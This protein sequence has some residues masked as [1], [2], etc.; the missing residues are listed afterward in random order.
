MAQTSQPAG[1][2]GAGADADTDADAEATSDQTRDE[3]EFYLEQMRTRFGTEDDGQS[4]VATPDAARPFEIETTPLPAKQDMFQPGDTGRPLDDSLIITPTDE[5]PT[6]FGDLT[7]DETG[8]AERQ[9]AE[10]ICSQELADLKASTLADVGLDIAVAG[11]PGEDYP[12]ECSIDDGTW[13]AGRS[14]PQTVYMWK[15]SA[16]CHKPLYFEDEAMERYGHSWGPCCDPIVSGVHFFSRLPILP[17]CMG[18]QPPCECVYALGHYRPG[19]CAPYLID[20]VPI[21]ARGALFQAGAV[22]G[23]A[24]ILP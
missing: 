8:D 15:A 12:F 7:R 1:E 21:S 4:G 23:A 14:W 10:S 20:P 19:S 16:L 24:A 13:H 11:M 6:D 5:L 2:A 9:L 3:I 18:D 22:V 17:Y